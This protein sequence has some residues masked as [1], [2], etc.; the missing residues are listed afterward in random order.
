MWIVI[1]SS[2][3]M[4]ESRGNSNKDMSEISNATNSI[5]VWSDQ[6]MKH[7]QTIYLFKI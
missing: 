7:V 4:L 2:E 6:F 5:A 1:T 3:L